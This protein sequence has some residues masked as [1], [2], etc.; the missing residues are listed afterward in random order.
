MRTVLMVVLPF[1]SPANRRQPSSRQSPLL[2]MF[3]YSLACPVPVAMRTEGISIEQ[4]CHVGLGENRLSDLT[5]C[6]A[7]VHSTRFAFTSITG[8]ESGSSS[9]TSPCRLR[10]RTTSATH[11]VQAGSMSVKGTNSRTNVGSSSG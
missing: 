1:P 6:M 3:Q 7:R 8:V 4:P 11:P 5:E 10:A 9:D 2:W